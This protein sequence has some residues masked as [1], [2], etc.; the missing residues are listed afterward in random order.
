MK[1]KLHLIG[2]AIIL[3]STVCSKIEHLALIGYVGKV[4]GYACLLLSDFS[5]TTKQL[6]KVS[7]LLFSIILMACYPY[8][9]LMDESKIPIEDV[10]CLSEARVGHNRKFSLD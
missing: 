9:L 6:I 4:V 7:V 5:T 2:H 8:P 10:I 1:N 3:V